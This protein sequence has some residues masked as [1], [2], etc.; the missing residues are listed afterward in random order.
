MILCCTHKKRRLDH[1]SHI[2]F[3][4]LGNFLTYQKVRIF[5][6]YPLVSVACQYVASGT[7][8]CMLITEYQAWS[9]P[10]YIIHTNGL[11]HPKM[12]KTFEILKNGVGYLHPHQTYTPQSQ[13]YHLYLTFLF[14]FL[15][16]EDHSLPNSF[17]LSLLQSL[18]LLIR[19]STVHSSYL[20]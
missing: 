2:C 1:I 11:N 8:F 18:K 17:M 4:P 3:P 15:S 10:R 12:V 9:C 14:V 16:Q 7:K 5:L 13:W 19:S 20:R 6:F